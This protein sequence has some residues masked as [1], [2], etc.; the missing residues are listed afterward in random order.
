MTTA[1]TASASFDFGRVVSNTFQVVMANFRELAIL[2]VLLAGLPAALLGWG[3]V[4]LTTPIE[5]G[6]ASVGSGLLLLIA[7]YIFSLIGSVL[8]QATTVR[9]T[10]ATLNGDPTSAFS[11]LGRSMSSILPLIGLAI[12]IG[13]SV[14]IGFL[15]LIVPGVILAVVWIVATPA[16][17]I[18]RPGVFGSL[19]RSRRLTSGHRWPIFGLLVVYI[20]AYIVISTVVSGIFGVAA[21]IGGGFS[22][23]AIAA[24]ASNAILG[25]ASGVLLSAGVA[26]I[27]YEL[28]MI[29]EGVG[30]AQ[31]AAVF[32]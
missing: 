2:A 13:L 21:A 1:P 9:A 29:K 17:V 32:D 4:A 31:L 28:R 10:V 6:A 14:A 30:P 3:Q 15:F 8:L 20:V 11:E 12:V 23:M 18:E 7:G 22:G 24:T 25:A 16:Y 5:G 19:G 26:A 27:Y